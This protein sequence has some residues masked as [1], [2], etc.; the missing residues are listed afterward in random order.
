MM[1]PSVDMT[2]LS[3]AVFGQGEQW[4]PRPGMTAA[5]RVNVRVEVLR[6]NGSSVFYKPVGHKAPEKKHQE[7]IASFLRRY[8]PV[9]ARSRERL[10]AIVKETLDRAGAPPFAEAPERSEP[11]VVVA[12]D[13]DELG[14]AMADEVIERTAPVARGPGGPPR[15][16]SAEVA[17]EVVGLYLAGQSMPEIS[18]AYKLR[19]S[20]IWKIVNRKTYRDVTDDLFE[21][22]ERAAQQQPQ[23]ETPMSVNNTAVRHE[24]EPVAPIHVEIHEVTPRPVESVD[25]MVDD[26]RDLVAATEMLLDAHIRGRRLPAYVSLSAIE[27]LA[28][29]VKDGLAR[30]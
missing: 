4:R 15:S 27:I 10:D 11:E 21:A 17:R 19:S 26:V 30:A 5:G 1:Q 13:T 20:T 6:S 29:K 22:H 14:Q 24:E 25:T 7:P 18:V 8:E 9:S 2:R 23:E 28:K 3:E 16:I 12:M